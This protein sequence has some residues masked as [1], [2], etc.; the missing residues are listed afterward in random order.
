MTAET[1]AKSCSRP[2]AIIG[3]EML[4]RYVPGR[5]L[6]VDHPRHGGVPDGFDI[7]AGDAFQ[8]VDSNWRDTDLEDGV[9]IF[10]VL[11]R[12]ALEGSAGVSECS[13]GG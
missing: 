10:E 8:D 6:T 12:Q 11:R 13:E 3:D 2:V 9:R 7:Q 5:H 1:S 4:F